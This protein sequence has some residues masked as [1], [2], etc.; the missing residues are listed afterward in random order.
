MKKGEL[1]EHMNTSEMYY[2]VINCEEIDELKEILNTYS[3]YYSQWRDYVNNIMLS[4]GL[5]YEKLGKKCGFSK[6]TIKSWI[7]NN[8][9]PKSRESFIKLGMGLRFNLQE[10]NYMLQRYG[11]Y[12]RLYSKSLEDAIGIYVISHYPKDESFNPYEYCIQLKSKFLNI[13]K[14]KNKRKYL[15]DS[16]NETFQVEEKLLNLKSEEELVAFVR[17]NEV[18]YINSY[19]KLVDYIEAYI[20]VENLGGSYHSLVKAEKLDKGFEKM[21][22]NL[23]NWG[24]VPNRQRLIALGIKLNMSCVEINQLLEYANMEKLCPK[25]KIECIILYVLSNIDI[26]NPEYQTNH[27]ALVTSYSNNPKIKE[28]CTRLLVELTGLKNSEEI[29]RDMQYYISD[30]LKS[31]D[32]DEDDYGILQ[33]FVVNRN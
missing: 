28:Q 12:P 18:E 11:K 26:S 16:P 6:N 9:V 14:T 13:L 30:T 31:L 2:R 29:E 22:S 15:A 7:K 4:K 3:P 20:K 33:L 5:S 23:K 32:M 10:I 8:K 24:E 25:D 17:E 27:M 21:L 1:M 19:Y